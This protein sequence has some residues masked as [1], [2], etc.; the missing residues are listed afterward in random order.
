LDGGHE[1]IVICTRNFEPVYD[2]ETFIK[3]IPIVI[4]E[5]PDVKF[6]IKGKGSLENKLKNLAKQLGVWDSVQFI[7]FGPYH[8]VPLYLNAADI[9]VSTSISE[10]G[11][12]SLWEA[13]AAGLPMVVT[14]LPANTEW[15]K[16][17]VNG[18]IVPIKDHKLLAAKIIELLK[19]KDLQKKFREKNI[20]ISKKKLD[21]NKMIN[22]LEKLYKSL[23]ESYN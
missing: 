2:V 9:Y 6:V 5:Y 23:I 19:N 22:Q 3:S 15:I 1:Q 12:I 16:D 8:E 14:D 11:S 18:Y 7:G 4:K 10:G 20:E 13:M 21:Q 17:G